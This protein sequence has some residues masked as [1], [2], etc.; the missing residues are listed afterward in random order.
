[1][2]NLL[3]TVAVTSS[4]LY[5]VAAIQLLVRLGNQVLPCIPAMLF[6]AMWSLHGV[7][8]IRVDF[9]MVALWMGGFL[10]LIRRLTAPSVMHKWLTWLLPVLPLS[11]AVFAPMVSPVF[12]VYPMLLCLVILLMLVEIVL[13][14]THGTLRAISIAIGTLVLFQLYFYAQGIATAALSADLVGARILLNATIVLLLLG[15]PLYINTD[16]TFVRQIGLSR[17]MA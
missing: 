8:T 17:P 14:S 11:A 13:R 2:E 10:V 3:V 16:R 15:S 5:L 12:V 6:M 4:V 7:S 9:V 1:M